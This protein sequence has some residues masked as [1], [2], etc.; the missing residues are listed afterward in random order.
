MKVKELIAELNKIDPTGEEE[1]C[2]DNRDIHFVEL[3][4]AYYDGKLQ[5]LI[6]DE[7]KQGN[8]IVG[9]K[10][11][12]KGCKVV[13]HYL[14][15]EDVILDYVDLPV[16]YSE[17]GSPERIAEYIEMVEKWREETR[18]IDKEIEEEANAKRANQGISK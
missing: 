18:K 12:T 7:K 15:I 14:G 17:L 9:A 6:R 10:F 3:L 5:R 16:D 11:T 13:I 8:N 1:V 4:P 2:I